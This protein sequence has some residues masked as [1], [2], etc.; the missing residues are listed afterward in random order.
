MTLSEY[1]Y[2]QTI[3]GLYD[4]TVGIRLSAIAAAM[5]VTKVSVFKAVE[6]LEHDSLIARDARNRVIMTRYARSAMRAYRR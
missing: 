1:R 6:R 2:L 4:G 3:N 5:D